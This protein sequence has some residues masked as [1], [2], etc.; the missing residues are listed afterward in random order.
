MIFGIT[1]SVCSRVINM[2]LKR[3]VTILRLH[4]IARVKF[5]DGNKMR[6]F[7]DMVQLREPAVN[8]IIGFMDDVSFPAECTEK[9]IKQNCSIVDMIVVR[10]LTTHSHMTQMARCSSVPLTFQEVGQM[11]ALRHNFCTRLRKGLVLTKFA[12]IR[13]SHGVETHLACLLVR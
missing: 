9:R 7:A 10:W 8:D 1:P 13:V 5:P 11:V 3:V 2:M 6:E 4:P 12:L